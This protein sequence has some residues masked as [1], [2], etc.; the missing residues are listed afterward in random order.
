VP[1]S[2]L[3]HP[4]C[5]Y[6]SYIHTIILQTSG[7][8]TIINKPSLF[9][10]LFLSDCLVLVSFLFVFFDFF[11]LSFPLFAFESVFPLFAFESVFPLFAFFFVLSV[12][13]LCSLTCVCFLF[14]GF[15]FTPPVKNQL[16]I[17]QKILLADFIDIITP[18]N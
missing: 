8:F 10:P 9:L 16:Q 18:S 11:L 4:V 13:P 1:P 2:P 6:V 12:F 17:I 15:G 5:I 3:S 7:F 14:F